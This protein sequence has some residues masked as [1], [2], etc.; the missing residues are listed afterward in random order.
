MERSTVAI[1]GLALILAILYFV[2][3]A[4]PYVAVF[5]RLSGASATPSCWYS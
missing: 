1:L 2:V 3:I 5:G 4:A